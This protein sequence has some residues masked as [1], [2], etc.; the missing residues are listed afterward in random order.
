LIANLRT[1]DL[2]P[3]PTVDVA[4]Y[5]I[6]RLSPHFQPAPFETDRPIALIGSTG[7]LEIAVPNGSAAEQ[8]G[9]GIGVSVAVSERT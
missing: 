9:F 7:L 5:R 2:P 6:D 3:S 4:G 8:L 1:A